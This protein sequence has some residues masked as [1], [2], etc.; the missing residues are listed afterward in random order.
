[1]SAE[2]IAGAEVLVVDDQPTNLDLLA[3]LLRPCGFV[4][5]AATSGRRALQTVQ[6]FRPDILLLDVD[7]PEM[8][9]YEVCR[10]LKADPATREIPVLFL[11]AKDEAADKVAAFAAGGADYVTKPFHFDE[12]LARLRHQL[13]IA[14]L[15][16]E[17]ERAAAELR[18]VNEVLRRTGEELAARNAELQAANARLAALSYQD[19]LTGVANR[20]RFEEALAEAFPRPGA[21]ALVLLDLDHFKRLNDAH[22]HQHGDDCLVRAAALLQQIASDVGGLAARFGGEEFALL[23]PAVADNVA[24]ALAERARAALEALALPHAGS[25]RGVVTASFGVAT[26]GAAVASADALVAA[27]DAALYEAKNGGRNRVA[28]CA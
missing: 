16:A 14:R 19:G 9:G 12:V 1:M 15:S 24:V 10:R 26:R 28:V 7:M 3:G 11:S 20:R 13:R 25:A 6:A 27:A 23:L 22:G 21:L 4:V 17:T 8:D 2:E 5:R 18:T